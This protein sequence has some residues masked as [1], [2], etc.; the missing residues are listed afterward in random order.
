[1][2]STANAL[3]EYKKQEQNIHEDIH[4]ISKIVERCGEQLEGNSFY[5]GNSNL[6]S[7]FFVYK[8]INFLN[9][10][11]DNKVKKMIEIGFNAG[12]SAAVFLSVLPKDGSILFFDLNDHTYANPCYAYMKNKYPQVKD[13]MAG[14]SKITLP[15]YI[16]NHSEELGTYDCIH[17]DGGHQEDVVLSDIFYSDKLLK[18]GGIMILDDTQLKPIENQIS[19]LLESGYVFLYQ[20]PTYGFSHVAL[21]KVGYL[22]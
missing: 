11:L 21:M 19:N 14:D 9:I 3:K 2:N 4:E 6:T 7:W 18:V 15:T 12:H 1:M 20:I 22:S 16:N 13:F 17:V 5:H 10:I 8:R